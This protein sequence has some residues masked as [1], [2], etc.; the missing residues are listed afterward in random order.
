[1][2]SIKEQLLL[3]DTY[4]TR[5][6]PTFRDAG[7]SENK[8]LPLHRWVPWIAGFS[9]QFVQ[10]VIQ[11]YLPSPARGDCLILDPFAGVGTTLV[12][13]LKAG[14]NVLGFEINAY[15]AL[16]A[17]AKL[18]C[19]DID[20]AAIRRSVESFAQD[21]RSTE[22]GVDVAWRE[23][24]EPALTELVAGSRVVAPA[25]F[26]SRIPFFSPPVE[27]KVLLAL[28]ALQSLPPN[29]RP[30][31]K[32]ALGA[33]LVSVS[34]YTY[35]P[36]LSSRPGAGKPLI[37]NSSLAQ[38]LI[39]KLAE[40]INDLEWAREALP[41]SAWRRRKDVILGSYF[42]SGL[43]EAS[44]S[45]VVTSPPYMNNYHYVRNTRPQLY[46]LGLVTDPAHLKGYE[47]DSFG[48]FWQTVRQGP[49]ISLEPSLPELQA[50]L[51]VLRGTRVDKGAYGG[52]GWANYVATYVNDTWKLIN[53]LKHQL[54]HGATAV[55]VVG[56]S[57][58][59]GIEFKVDEIVSELGEMAGLVTEQIA[60][61]RT[62][63]V[64]NSII[65]STVRND[66][67]LV[68]RFQLYDA[69]VVLRQES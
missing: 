3:K 19:L 55:I 57:I 40:M 24:G 18:S 17:S 64:G 45:L 6:A 7:A 43:P 65:G 2:T 69:A 26:R 47:S 15:A 52:P 29:A 39:Q 54:A 25:V 20:P 21:V 1:V 36:S 32:V 22:V 28:D 37:E 9:G 49:E 10:D 16:A 44:V 48:K 66:G 34:N 31:A 61:V 67:G 8:A 14:A 62:K 41:P 11:E 5:V 60:I 38:P 68:N 30:L 56:N 12:E 53:L 50:S 23:G 42:E 33:T 4:G 27:A 58:I 63:R 51:D 35:E 46:W 13:G 59:Q